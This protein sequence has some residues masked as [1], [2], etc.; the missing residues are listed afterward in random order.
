VIDRT[1]LAFPIGSG[2]MRDQQGMTLRD[3]FA[4]RALQGILAN[5]AE[6]PDNRAAAWAY[7]AADAM[8]EE[9]AR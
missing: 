6:T 7:N 3:Y 2:D 1:T 5:N 4:A 8:M 9:R